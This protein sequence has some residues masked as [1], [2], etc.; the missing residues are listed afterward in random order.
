MLLRA[1]LRF[2]RLQNLFAHSILLHLNTT[3]QTQIFLPQLLMELTFI[4]SS[5]RPPTSKAD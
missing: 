5:R 4:L 2:E 3:L 1:A